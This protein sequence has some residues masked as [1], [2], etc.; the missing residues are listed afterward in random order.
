[1]IEP[2]N[3]IKILYNH[4]ITCVNLMIPYRDV[5]W[6]ILA[7]NFWLSDYYTPGFLYICITLTYL[8]V[9]LYTRVIFCLVF[10]H[11]VI[12]Y[13][14]N[15]THATVFLNVNATS[16]NLSVS[17]YTQVSYFSVQISH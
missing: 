6:I 1:M 3:N 12:L 10:Y 5:R 13:L 15:Y 9:Y 16:G 7:F 17:K 2:N 8:G 4:L 11:H 14:V